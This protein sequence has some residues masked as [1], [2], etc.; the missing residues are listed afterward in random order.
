MLGKNFI[1]TIYRVLEV[2]MAYL[3]CFIFACVE[4][5]DDSL[6]ALIDLLWFGLVEY[7]I[8]PIWLLQCGGVLLCCICCHELFTVSK[9]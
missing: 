5:T 9:C 6:T 4:L 8:I 7:F 3:A 1:L 2:G